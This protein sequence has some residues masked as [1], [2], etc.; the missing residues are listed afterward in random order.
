AR[1]R[2]A[3]AAA[4]AARTREADAAA[5]ATIISAR[6]AAGAREA[7]TR[8]TASTAAGDRI[9]ARRACGRSASGISARSAAAEPALESRAPRQLI[10]GLFA[11]CTAR[12]REHGDTG[13]YQRNRANIRI[14]HGFSSVRGRQ[15]V[16]TSFGRKVRMTPTSLARNRAIS[17]DKSFSARDNT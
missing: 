8:E 10:R 9:R 6:R 2:E 11:L 12:E 7:A 15:R 3:R 1:T 14:Q 5:R 17:L 13:S 16:Q 4:D